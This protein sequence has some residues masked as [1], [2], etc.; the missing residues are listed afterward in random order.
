MSNFGKKKFIGGMGGHYF[1]EKVAGQNRKE[2]LDL[3]LTLEHQERR[4]NLCDR[5]GIHPPIKNNHFLPG[6]FYDIELLCTKCGEMKPKQEFR[7]YAI[8]SSHSNNGFN[9]RC[10]DCQ[11]TKYTHG[12]LMDDFIDEDFIDEGFDVDEEFDVVDVDVDEEDGEEDDKEYTVEAIL[13]H[14]INEK[15]TLLFQVKWLGYKKTTWEPITYLYN[16]GL[17]E[18]YLKNNLK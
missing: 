11:V 15:N 17:F 8:H 2:R 5:Q 6:T 14:K 3:R 12:Y 9:I 13:N 10:R 1:E 4:T 7:N 18:T 16:V